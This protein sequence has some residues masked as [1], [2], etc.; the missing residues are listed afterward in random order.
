[1][2]NIGA[3]NLSPVRNKE[4]IKMKKKIRIALIGSGG[5]AH[6]HLT[7]IDEYENAEVVIACD[8][9]EEAAKKFAEKHGIENYTTDI[10]AV[11]AD[12]AIDAVT[13]ATPPAFHAPIALKALKAGKH[14]HT[15]K[16]FAMNAQEAEE[17]VN[18][19]K[20][21][22]LIFM[23]G[24]NQ[25]YTSE[26]QTAK[27][28]VEAGTLGEVYHAKALWKRRNFIPGGVGGWFH[29]KKIA[30]G[31]AML[32]IGVHLLD[33]CMYVIDNF[34]PVSVSGAVYTKFGPYG[35]LK[36]ASTSEM[37]EPEFSVDDYSFALIKMENGSTIQ[38][39]ATWAEFMEQKE[40][41]NIEL[42]GTDAGMNLRPMKLFKCGSEE[43]SYEIIEPKPFEGEGN[44]KKGRTYNWLEAI[45]G[46]AEVLCKPEQSLAI[47]KIID[48]I[49]ES[50][51]TGRE[52]I[53]DWS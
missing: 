18:L 40:Y 12:K 48:A 10:D 33:L 24:M 46:K 20:E 30:G 41:S 50:S 5:I 17:V 29:N 49:Y 7:G 26:G 36:P 47:Q 1:M 22:G 52:V 6:S 13:I 3:K 15:D 16:P 32:D 25:R 42:K 21:K 44:I 9:N 2:I 8:V 39:E 53:I 45:E 4:K 27:Q 43:G 31:G 28:I 38:L 23:V 51:K 35:G 34:K 11:M 14:V 19:A 37:V